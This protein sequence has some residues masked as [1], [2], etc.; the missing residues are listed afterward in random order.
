MM[1]ARLSHRSEAHLRKAVGN[2]PAWGADR[3]N[4][5]RKEITA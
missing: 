3:R 1:T 5:D 4:L 2:L